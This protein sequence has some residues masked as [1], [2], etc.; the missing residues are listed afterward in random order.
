M[1]HAKDTEIGV[2]D[3]K[4][5]CLGLID[6]V[7]QGKSGRV[8]LTRHNKPVAALVPVGG[9]KAEL[10]GAMRGTVK[11]AARVDLTLPTGEVWDA[12]D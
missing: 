11:L 12:N 10:W 9:E 3:F 8:L 5:K 1:E 2:T 6:K 4:A 7:A